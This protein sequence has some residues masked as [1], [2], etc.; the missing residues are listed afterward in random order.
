M[1]NLERI[2][3]FCRPL[4]LAGRS[5]TVR[6]RNAFPP[7]PSDATLIVENVTIEYSNR[8]KRYTKIRLVFCRSLLCSCYMSRREEKEREKEKRI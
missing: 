5:K 6:P 3:P 8:L 1:L 2:L 4:L 7:H